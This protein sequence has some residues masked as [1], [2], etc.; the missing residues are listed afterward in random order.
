[1]RWMPNE[2][3][4][5]K[6]QI[7]QVWKSSFPGYRVGS[8]S[9]SKLE[10]INTHCQ[11]GCRHEPERCCRLHMA[12]QRWAQVLVG[13][14][15]L[16]HSTMLAA[17]VWSTW[18]ES[19]HRPGAVILLPLLQ[20]PHTF[21]CLQLQIP[22]ASSHTVWWKITF[23]LNQIPLKVHLRRVFQHKLPW[24]LSQLKKES[25]LLNHDSLMLQ[26]GLFAYFEIMHCGKSP[27]KIRELG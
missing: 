27:P 22:R 8:Y 20:E 2:S 25:D 21:H 4:T 10:R 23:P 24:S 18:T 15:P 19:Q 3:L 26:E 16:E 6:D 9:Q 13:L 7:R 17:G 12:A 5:H 14:Q 11:P 1:M